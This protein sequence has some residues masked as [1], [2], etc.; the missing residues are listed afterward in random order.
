M[1]EQNSEEKALNR[2]Y[3]LAYLVSPNIA[4][5]KLAEQVSSIKALLEKHGAF[6]ISEEYPKFRQLAYNMVKPMGGKNEKYSN[7]YFGWVKFEVSVE[8]ALSIK[9]E[10]KK[11]SQLVRLLIV[12]TE[13]ET[14]YPAK[15]AFWKDMPKREV[16]AEPKTGPSMSEAEIDKTIE[17]L[18]VE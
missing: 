15:T 3:E 5:D 14:K 9:D 11:M 4:E 17:E 12:K 18:V 16:K 1:T 7:A 10:L 13:R 6:V 2:V 8:G